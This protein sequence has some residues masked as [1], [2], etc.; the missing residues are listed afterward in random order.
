M[1]LCDHKNSF[2]MTFQVENENLAPVKRRQK[3]LKQNTEII[4]IVQ[5]CQ[6]CIIMKT[7]IIVEARTKEIL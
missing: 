4:L 3:R 2:V 5:W 7:I 1:T 6:I